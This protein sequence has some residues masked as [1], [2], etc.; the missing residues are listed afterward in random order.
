[1]NNPKIDS[2]YLD[3]RYAIAAKKKSFF[4]VNKSKY[5]LWF[6]RLFFL[7]PAFVIQ[8]CWQSS[9]ADELFC[10]ILKKVRRPP[11]WKDPKGHNNKSQGQKCYFWP[12]HS[13]FKRIKNGIWP[14]K[15]VQTYKQTRICWKYELLFEKRKSIGNLEK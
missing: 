8:I 6:S 9:Y 4:V 13:S 15:Y 14:K 7:S 5:L 11:K 1:M 2:Y 10:Q 12:T 3:N